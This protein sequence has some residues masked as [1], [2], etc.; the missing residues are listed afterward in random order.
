MI[1]HAMDAVKAVVTHLH[2]EPAPVIV[3]DQPLYS[4]ATKLQWN[5]PATHGEDKYGVCLGGMHVEL[6]VDKSLGN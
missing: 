4:L 5:F 2:P 1:Y 3:A 6:T